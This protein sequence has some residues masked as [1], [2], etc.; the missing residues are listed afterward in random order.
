MSV[1]HNVTRGAQDGTCPTRWQS[2]HGR[3]PLPPE[4]AKIA[5]R[6]VWYKSEVPQ[7]LD[8]P[9]QTSQAAAA[10]A[11]SIVAALCWV[12]TT[13]HECAFERYATA[14]RSVQSLPLVAQ[15]GY[16]DSALPSVGPRPAGA[17]RRPNT[18]GED[19]MPA[20]KRPK[21]PSEGFGTNRRCPSRSGGPPRLT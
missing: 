20:R 6:G 18:A 11:S 21:S 4:N 13:P 10:R 1:F 17:H 19:S 7:P 15:N 16:Q 14:C 9:T 5:L 8:R 3:F 12:D 2:C